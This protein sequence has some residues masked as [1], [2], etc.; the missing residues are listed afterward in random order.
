MRYRVKPG[1]TARVLELQF[2]MIPSDFD[3]VKKVIE[4]IIKISK[5]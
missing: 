5:E 4:A 1:M 2:K 3:D